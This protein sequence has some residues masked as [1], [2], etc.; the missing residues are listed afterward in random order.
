M[1]TAELMPGVALRLA[2]ERDAAE[3]YGLVD[4]NRA[5]LA[6]WMP[7]AQHETRDQVLDYIRITRAQV[8]E[9]N[10]LNTVITVDG[11]LAGS[12]GMR[13]ISWPDGSTE[14]G[15]WLAERHQ[16]RG[17][18]TAGVRAYLDYAFDTLGLNRVVISAGVDNARSRA[19]AERLG[20][21]LEGVHREAER[22]GDRAHD[23]AVYAMLAAEWAAR[24]AADH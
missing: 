24:R 13:S 2:E 16:G 14:L 8:G 20:F 7:W 21:A 18:I 9:N 5:Y 22:I 1:L 12:L 4:G 19:V 10:G 6:R 3:I 23:L 17:I 11:R 15:Y